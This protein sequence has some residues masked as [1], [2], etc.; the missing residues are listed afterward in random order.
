[1]SYACLS[2]VT[3]LRDRNDGVWPYGMEAMADDCSRRVDDTRECI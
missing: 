3:I 2:Y 1:M